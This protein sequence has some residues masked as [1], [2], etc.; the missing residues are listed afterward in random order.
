MPYWNVKHDISETGGLLFKEDKLIIPTSM[1]KDMLKLIHESHLGIEKCKARA[2]SIIYWPGMSS[3]VADTV[4]KCATCAEHRNRNCKEP[5][6]P[7]EIPECPWQK[8]GSDLYEYKG[9]TYLLVVDYYSKYIDMSL[10]YG[11]KLQQR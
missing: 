1:R 5:M 9:K 4:S 10:Y 7:H 11:T 3:D 8:L 6:I 2:R